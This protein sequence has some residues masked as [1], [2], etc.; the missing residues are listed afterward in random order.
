VVHG[1]WHG[2]NLKAQAEG[3]NTAG[4]FLVPS[5]FETA[6]IDLREEYG[7]FRNECRMVPMGSD[8]MTIPRRA[9]A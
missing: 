9:A 5:E 4:G 6:I 7:L 1:E 8:S 3:V 2:G